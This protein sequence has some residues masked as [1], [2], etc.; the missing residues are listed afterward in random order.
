M[1]TPQPLPERKPFTFGRYIPRIGR[2]SDREP[3]SETQKQALRQKYLKVINEQE[4]TIGMK[5]MADRI[6][7]WLMNDRPFVQKAIGLNAWVLSYASSTIQEDRELVLEALLHWPH[8]LG[9]LPEKL[10]AD[11]EI[12]MRAVKEDG[13]ALLHAAVALRDDDEVVFGAIAA[14]IHGESAYYFASER[15]QNSPTVLRNFYRACDKHRTDYIERLKIQ[16]AIPETLRV[17]LEIASGVSVTKAET[18][19]QDRIR[20]TEKIRYAL[21]TLARQEAS[22]KMHEYLKEQKHTIDVADLHIAT[23]TA[24][25]VKPPARSKNRI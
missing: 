16:N 1:D 21:E 25:L 10:R 22:Q 15:L 19:T 5:A 23:P 20:Q 13:G 9:R 24:T 18:M 3:T 8:L 11:K 14:T 4:D 2:G 12:V 7:V 6:P 17:K